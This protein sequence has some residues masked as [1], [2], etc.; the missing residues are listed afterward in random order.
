MNPLYWNSFDWLQATD[1]VCMAGAIMC[2]ISLIAHWRA[3]VKGV[4]SHAYSVLSTTFLA[5][6]CLGMAFAVATRWVEVNH[7]PSQNMNEVLGMFTTA[8][9]LSMLVLHFALGLHRRGAGW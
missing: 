7:F 6:A 4:T 3:S 1:G 8:L 9:V 2:V 5:L